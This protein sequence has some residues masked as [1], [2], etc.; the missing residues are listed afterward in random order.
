MIHNKLMKII[1]YSIDT[2]YQFGDN[3]CNLIVLRIIDLFAGT[4]LSIREYTSVKE[5]IAGLNKE[6]WNHTGEI[7]EAYCDEVTHVIDGDIWL[8]PDNL[9]I[10]AVVVSG[11]VLGVNDE[12]NGFVLQPIPKKGK[13]YRVRKQD[14]G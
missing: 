7:V 12:H 2:P 11:R 14:N 3:D 9:L 5:G 1:Q 6:G 13:Y 8:D 4:S 10:M